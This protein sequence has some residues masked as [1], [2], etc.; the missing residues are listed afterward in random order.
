M[1]YTQVTHC[2][3]GTFKLLKSNVPHNLLHENNITSNVQMYCFCSLG[4]TLKHTFEAR[5]VYLWHNMRKFS[6]LQNLKKYKN[7]TNKTKEEYKINRTVK[8]IK[9]KGSKRIKKKL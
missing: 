5:Q 2:Y 3:Y 4:I 6:I 8:H 7:K 1:I 9:S